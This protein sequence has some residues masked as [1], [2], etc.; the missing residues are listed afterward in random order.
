[1][2]FPDYSNMTAEQK[3]NLTDV[4]CPGPCVDDKDKCSA[5]AS[6]VK[7]LVEEYP[8]MDTSGILT[9]KTPIP[10]DEVWCELLCIPDGWIR[11]FGMDLLQ[12]LKEAATKSSRYDEFKA[13]QWKE[14]YA[15]LRLYFNF[16][17]DEIDNIVTK[18]EFMSER[19]C[20]SCGKDA[21]WVSTGWVCPYCD[22]CKSR[23]DGEK[24]FRP[25]DTWFGKPGGDRFM[26]SYKKDENP[27]YPYGVVKSIWNWDTSR[28][29]PYSKLHETD[30]AFEKRHEFIHR[31][32]ELQDERVKALLKEYDKY[33]Y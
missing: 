26:M 23:L 30:Y 20:A 10:D 25:I 29:S 13:I 17:T 21:T 28:W 1:M 9:T 16:T 22:D 31:L 18:Y 4:L 14:K 7:A 11:R 8:F 27:A 2:E 6:V 3:A 24:K 5:R 33:W 15:Q 32:D 12:D 19:V